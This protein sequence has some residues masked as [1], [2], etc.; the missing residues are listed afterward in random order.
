L[1]YDADPNQ[2]DATAGAGSSASTE[3]RTIV[4]LLDLAHHAASTAIELHQE[5]EGGADA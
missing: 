1:L 4:P 5:A 3:L 2:T